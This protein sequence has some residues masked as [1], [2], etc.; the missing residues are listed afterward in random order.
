MPVKASRKS[1]GGWGAKQGREEAST[2]E[3]CFCP[4]HSERFVLQKTG[5]S[6]NRSF[7]FG[8]FMFLILFVDNC[9][10]IFDTAFNLQICM[11]Y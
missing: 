8:D 1:D 7:G 10:S 2:G 9:I 3:I 11:N 6:V 4:Q 5:N